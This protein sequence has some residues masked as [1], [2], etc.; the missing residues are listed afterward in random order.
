MRLARDRAPLWLNSQIGNRLG[1]GTGASDC[2]K[3]RA[4]EASVP[5][6]RRLADLA[7]AGGAA[8]DRVPDAVGVVAPRLAEDVAGELLPASRAAHRVAPQEEVEAQAGACQ[9]ERKFGRA[10]NLPST[11]PRK[12]TDADIGPHNLGGARR[13]RRGRRE[14][15]EV[16]PLPASHRRVVRPKAADKPQ[17][18]QD[19]QD[20]PDRAAEAGASISAAGVRGLKSRLARPIKSFSL[21]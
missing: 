9:G 5:C 15:G 13:A 3:Q 7:A 20:K 4:K 6:A 14:C 11:R 19:H 17:D 8:G 18:Y 10:A 21:Q 16:N 12:P 1:G 2:K